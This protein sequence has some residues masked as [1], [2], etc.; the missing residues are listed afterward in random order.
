MSLIVTKGLGGSASELM[1]QGYSILDEVLSA[2]EQVPRIIH[3]GSSKKRRQQEREIIV[4]VKLKS[5]DGESIDASIEGYSRVT[6]DSVKD[7]KIRMI[8]HVKSVIGDR[9][10]DIKITVNRVK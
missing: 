7:Y 10:R 6:V 9:W 3:G 4:G 5:V 2:I 1:L 8:K